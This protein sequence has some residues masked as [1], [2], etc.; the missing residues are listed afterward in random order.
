MNEDRY[1]PVEDAFREGRIQGEDSATLGKY[2]HALSNQPI[3]NDLVRH[4]DIIRGITINHI[5]LQRHIADLDRKNTNTQRLVIVLT[6]ASVLTGAL[7]ILYAYRA[8][9]RSVLEAERTATSVT[10]RTEAPASPSSATTGQR[11]QLSGAVEAAPPQ[12]A[13]PQSSA[14]L[15]ASK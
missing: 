8:D 7:Q 5:L 11:A 14:A 12:P 9:N 15:P 3:H 2:L 4:R 6:V 1:Q 13:T 10:V